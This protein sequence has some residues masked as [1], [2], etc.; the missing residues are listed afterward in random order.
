VTS[1]RWEPSQV[2]ILAANWK[3]MSHAEI[4]SLVG[5]TEKSVR[6]KCWR[7]GFVDVSDHWS[8]AEIQTLTIAYQQAS[9][10]EDIDLDGLSES[11]GRHKTNICRKAREF[12]LTDN[13]R[14]KLATWKRKIRVPRFSTKEE[15]SKHISERTKKFFAD[16]GH[17][18]GALG[19]KHTDKAKMLIAEK[20]AARWKAMTNEQKEDQ[21]M[22]C[23]I[24]RRAAGSK[25]MARGSWKAAW[26]EFGGKRVFYRSRW[27]ANYGRYLEFLKEHGEIVDWHHEAHTFWFEGIKRGCVSY[28]P[29]FKVE[30]RNGSIEWHEVKGW[31]DARSKTVLKRMAKYHPKEKMILI[32]EKQYKEIERKISALI[33]GWEK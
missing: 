22:K 7:L 16:N 3:S 32:Q 4:G 11:L 24:G 6:N 17:P 14:E 2:E 29:D 19:M 20:S 23:A 9:Y 33:P 13:G 26:R 21:I 5:K 12:G 27:E 1:Y 10:S 18:R 30:N 15:L 28:L 8:D 25:P 31:M